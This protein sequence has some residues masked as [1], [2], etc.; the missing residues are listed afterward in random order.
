[1]L[2]DQDRTPNRLAFARLV[3]IRRSGRLIVPVRFGRLR[4]PYPKLLDGGT[5]EPGEGV[6]A[7]GE[8]IKA[9]KALPTSDVAR[10]DL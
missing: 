5:L 9:A 4:R 6:M 8:G 10:C 2:G 7:S 1:V 3:D